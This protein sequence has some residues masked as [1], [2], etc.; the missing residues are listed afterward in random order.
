MTSREDIEML[1]T[2]ADRVGKQRASQRKARKERNQVSEADIAA[3]ERQLNADIAPA[4][5][6]GIG[7]EDATE[8]ERAFGQDQ[9]DLQTDFREYSDSGDFER[10]DVAPKSVMQDAL[11][12]LQQQEQNQIRIKRIIY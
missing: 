4:E 9:S 5:L 2:G 12:R 6:R 11:R 3:I 10:P 7:L 8:I 1:I